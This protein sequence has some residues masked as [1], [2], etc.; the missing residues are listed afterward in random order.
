MPSIA[1]WIFN[2]RPK[3]EAASKEVRLLMDAMA[4]RFDVYLYSFN[5]NEKK[6]CLFGKAK[7]IPLPIGAGLLPFYFH[8][9]KKY[10]INHLFASPAERMLSRHLCKHNSVL[11]ITKDT[12]SLAR[13]ERNLPYLKRFKSVVV[14]SDRHKSLLVQGGLKETSVRLVYPGFE[15]KPYVKA[16]NPFT[17]LFAT[18]PLHNDDFLS[19]GIYLMIDVAKRMP[20]IQF[21]FIWR[22]KAYQKL[23]QLV[24]KSTVENILVRNELIPDMDPVY[25]SVHAVILPGLE[26]CSLKPCPHSGIE[27]ISHGKPV[28]ASSASSMARIINSEKCG[29]IFDPDSAQLIQSILQLRDNYA[30]YQK[31]C[32]GV[33]KKYFSREHY[34]DSY[35]QIYGDLIQLEA[36]KTIQLPDGLNGYKPSQEGILVPNRSRDEI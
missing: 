20:D 21:V 1:Y 27:G 33:I 17:I 7:K 25:Q 13:F 35:T 32:S 8:E 6:P 11:T 2:Y 16:G 22:K 30:S 5:F 3:W 9:M 23:R 36:K 28:L 4:H 34:I 18:S 26:S 15:E 10:T 29:I 12:S 31:N 19:R 14:E 24:K